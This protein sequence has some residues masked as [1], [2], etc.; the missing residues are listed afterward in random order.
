MKTVLVTGST[1]S[2]GQAVIQCLQ[3]NTNVE[4]IATSRNSKDGYTQLDIGDTKQLADLLERIRPDL[5]MHLAAT[6][7][8]DFD[9]A[10]AINVEV[11]RNLLETVQQSGLDPRVIFIGSAAEYGI[12]HPQDNP[13]SEDHVLNPVSVYGLTKAWQTQVAGLYAARGVNV[14]VARVFNLSG[15]NISEK[16][17]IGRLQKQISEVL[18]GRQSIIELG[19]LGASRDY[20]TVDE[21]ADQ[22]LTIAEHGEPGQVYNVASGSAVLM[23]DLMIR[24]LEQNGLDVSIVRESAELTNRT[25]YDVPI[26]YADITKTRQLKDLRAQQCNEIK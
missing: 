21:A 24:I 20:I 11:S 14:L 4:I 6:F 10:Y 7:I 5:I 19:P 16:L 18:A 15:E 12:I 3:K 1:G 13:V 9:K 17:F 2:L 8:N 23:R 25:G 22:I 26:I